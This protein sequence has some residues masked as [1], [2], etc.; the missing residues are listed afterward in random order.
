MKGDYIMEKRIN[1]EKIG[2]QYTLVGDYYLP[3]LAMPDEGIRSVGVYGRR[4]GDYLKRNRR[5]A[6]T[7]LLTSGKLHSY[8]ADVDEQARVQ[9][10]LIV[11]Q[12][13]E[14]EGITEKLKAENQMMGVQKMNNIRHRAE[15]IVVGE[16]IYG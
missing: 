4:H 11:K 2:I 13:A 3:D 16:I 8:L 1:S 6:Y 14:H 10:E 12:M 9:L 15:E 5:A 7:E